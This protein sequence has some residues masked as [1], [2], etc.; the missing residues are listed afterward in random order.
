MEIRFI[1][2]RCYLNYGLKRYKD[3]LDDAYAC[4]E[5]DQKR[6]EAMIMIPVAMCGMSDPKSAAKFLKNNAKEVSII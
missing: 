3:A 6:I 1:L 4:H 5:L 2:L